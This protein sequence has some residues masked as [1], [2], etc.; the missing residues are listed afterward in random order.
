M[1]QPQCG[2]KCFCMLKLL[3][4]AEHE[5]YQSASNRQFQVSQTN[6]IFS[7]DCIRSAFAITKEKSNN[8][9]EHKSVC[10]P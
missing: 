10:M 6:G 2:C 8:F 5:T 7:A 9:L 3:H 1:D 4:K